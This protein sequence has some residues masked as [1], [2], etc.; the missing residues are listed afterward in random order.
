MENEMQFNQLIA[1]YNFAFC[2]IVFLVLRETQHYI[3]DLDRLIEQ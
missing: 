1:C 2:G 3:H